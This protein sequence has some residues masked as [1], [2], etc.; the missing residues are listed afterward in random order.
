MPN[1]ARR[2][3]ALL[4]LLLSLMN[5]VSAAPRQDILGGASLIFIT[6]PKNPL[7]RQRAARSKKQKNAPVTS[8]PTPGTKSG[9]PAA[10]DDMSDEVEDA[11]ALGN[12]ARDAEPPRYQDA[13]RAYRLAA[14]L[15]DKDPR[16]YLGLANL[17]Y[18]KKNYEAAA[19]M[20]REATQRMKPKKVTTMGAFGTKSIEPGDSIWSTSSGRGEVHAYLGNSLLQ[21]GRFADAEKELRSATIED[22]GNAQSF[23][24]LGYSFFQQKKY[25]EA[26]EALQKATALAP[27][28]EAYKQLLDESRA[29]QQQ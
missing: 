9:N 24:L 10:S 8:E 23:A 5:L 29:R 11:L 2:V 13:E 15:N 16:P 12:S 20:Y 28:I 18:D 27:D 4:A 7:V 17:W 19:N 6:R 25:A 14:K 21:L 3:V 26:T 22:S 1:T